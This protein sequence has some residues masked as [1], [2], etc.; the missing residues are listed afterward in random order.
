MAK[1]PETDHLEEEVFDFVRK[2]EEAVVDAGR[3]WA[4]VVEEFIPVETPAVQELVKGILDFTEEILETQREF[5]HKMLD[6]VRTKVDEL[7]KSTP[8]EAKS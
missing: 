6:E 4:K 3:K 8:K 2:T 7:A 5:A 1:V